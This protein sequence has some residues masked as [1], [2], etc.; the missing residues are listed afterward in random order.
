MT[1][2]MTANIGAQRDENY[3]AL[4]IQ[5]RLQEMSLRRNQPQEGP[6]H[7]RSTGPP[8]A[9]QPTEKQINT[10]TPV[11]NPQNH[12]EPHQ[13][14][15]V[16]MNQD[17][18]NEF[19]QIPSTAPYAQYEASNLELNPHYSVV[20][21]REHAR[22]PPQQL[23]PAVEYSRLSAAPS[24]RSEGPRISR[25]ETNPRFSAGSSV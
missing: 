24:G 14:P 23:I 5:E 13:R 17:L 7:A 16:I 10:Y 19:D 22:R 9:Q 20:S 25:T 3:Q 6:D 18:F 12:Q 1:T 8:S 4:E 2:R 11:K 21:E 15:T